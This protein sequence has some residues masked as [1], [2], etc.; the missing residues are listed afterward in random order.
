MLLKNFS[1]ASLSTMTIAWRY[2][3]GEQR[4]QLN[5]VAVTIL[6][7][8]KFFRQKTK[9]VFLVSQSWSGPLVTQT[10]ST[11]GSL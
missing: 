1:F 8:L 3:P 10:D 11:N 6:S 5:P 4:V 7:S 9:Q 2:I